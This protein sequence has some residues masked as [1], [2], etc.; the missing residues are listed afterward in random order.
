VD[1][2]IYDGTQ[3]MRQESKMTLDAAKKA[4]GLSAVWNRISRKAEEVRKKRE[5][6]GSGGGGSSGNKG[7][8]E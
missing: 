7:K 5:S 6:S 4:M 8:G 1:E 2:V 3:R